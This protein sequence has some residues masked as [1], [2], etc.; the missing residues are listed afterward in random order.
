MLG[1][2]LRAQGRSEA[3]GNR[4]VRCRGVIHNAL[5]FD[6]SAYCGFDESKPLQIHEYT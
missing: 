1:K 5:M 2:D 4:I 6:L 3:A